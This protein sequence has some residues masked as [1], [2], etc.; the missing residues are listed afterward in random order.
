MG[1]GQPMPILSPLA[2]SQF[3]RQLQKKKKK[4]DD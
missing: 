2:W 4:D 3:F 1:Q